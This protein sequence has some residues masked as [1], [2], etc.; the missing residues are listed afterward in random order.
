VTPLQK[1]AA[2]AKSPLGRMHALYALD[3]LKALDVGTVLHGLRDDDPRVR[4]H[5]LRLAEPFASAAEVQTRL[6]QLCD[7]PDPRV[8]YQLAFSLGAVRGARPTQALVKLARRDGGDAWVRLAVLSSVNGRAAEVFRRLLADGEFRAA[9]HGRPFLL[10]LAAVIGRTNRADE[11]AALARELDALPAGEQALTKEI[12]RSLVAKL[13]AAGREPF[14]R[15]AGG[16]VG[17]V[18]A[19]LLR[20]ARQ[21]A[22]DAKC[23]VAARVA[24]VRTLGLAPFADNQGL[25]RELLQSRQPQAVQAAALEALGRFDEPGVPGLVLAA[26]PG[27]SPALRA[28]AVEV[29]FARPAGIAAFLDAVEQGKVGRGDVDPAR[30]QL[31]QAHADARLRARAAQL[32]AA[33]RPARRADVVAAYQ[34]ALQLK[35]DPARGK[36]VFK[37]ECSA[38]HQLQGI[39]TQVGADLNA[40]RGQT[41]DA[42]LLNILDPNRDVK[43]EFLTYVLTTTAGRLVT[44]MI[45]A[46]TAND[47]TLRRADGT[48][49]TVLRIDIEE[50]RSTGLSFMPEG[51]EKQIDVPAM[52]DLLA[53]L[54]SIK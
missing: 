25:F 20:D 8:R 54:R 5:A 53:Y 50:L 45:T 7:D 24:A 42:I 2:A 39:G 37:K 10:A 26:W 33:T 34:R 49:E 23:P 44:G 4:E 15:L 16:K 52:A 46:E 38:C 18:L 19:D 40:V 11:I 35:G 29:L 31:L 47:L 13:P 14:A 9:P 6:E 43:P 27:L 41:S 21:T 28:G 48:S 51:Q 32:F 17:A 36:A 30:V 1:L 12:V 3:G 22:P